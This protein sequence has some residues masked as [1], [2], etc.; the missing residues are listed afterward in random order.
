MAELGGR[1]IIALH[2]MAD[3]WHLSLC[4]VFILCQGL[5]AALLEVIKENS[6]CMICESKSVRSDPEMSIR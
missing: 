4:A 3:Y 6:S 1:R 2:F 5:S